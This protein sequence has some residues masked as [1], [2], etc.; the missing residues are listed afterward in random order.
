MGFSLKI[1]PGLARQH[2]TMLDKRKKDALIKKYATHAGDTGSSEVQI[3][4]LTEE[5]RELTDHLKTHKKDFSSRRGL[6]R[7]VSQRKRLLRYLERENAESFEK[8]TKALKIKVS[9][10]AEEEARLNEAELTEGEV[11][12][13]EAVA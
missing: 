3:A 5:I 9:R 4:I 6:L 11:V 1:I 2:K 12:P 8:L 13:E 10:R 7:K